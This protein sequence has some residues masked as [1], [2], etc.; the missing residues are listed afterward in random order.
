MLNLLALLDGICFLIDVLF[1]LLNSALIPLG[2][3][4]TFL[5]FF[6]Q[7]ILGTNGLFLDFQE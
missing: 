1:L 4:S 7:F 5:D 3:R 6:V 2:F